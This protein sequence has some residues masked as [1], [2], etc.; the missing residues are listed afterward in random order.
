MAQGPSQTGDKTAKGTPPAQGTESALSHPSN[1]QPWEDKS[2]A[3]GDRLQAYKDFVREKVEGIKAAVGR[4]G[5]DSSEVLEI[6]D[7]SETQRWM[8]EARLVQGVSAED[9]CKRIDRPEV[10]Q[11]LGKNFLGSEAWR[12]QGIEVEGE[13][14]IPG[15]ITRE[16]LESECPFHP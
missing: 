14:P 11:L 16:L 2:L 12:S 8:E 9:F 3:P 1:L 15:S 10:R 6:R 13:P 7:A 4:L 5:E